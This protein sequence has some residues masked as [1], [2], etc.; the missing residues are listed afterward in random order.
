MVVWD[1][2]TWKWTIIVKWFSIIV[3]IY[4]LFFW[5]A[6]IILFFILNLHLHFAL[7]I[8]DME[9]NSV[10]IMGCFIAAGIGGKSEGNRISVEF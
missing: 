5:L 4:L 1:V 9:S 3:W 8:W 10:A 6:S 2:R 7:R